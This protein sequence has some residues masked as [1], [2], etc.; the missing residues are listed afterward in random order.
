MSRMT[1]GI[2]FTSSDLNAFLGAEINRRFRKRRVLM[3]SYRSFSDV[4]AWPFHVVE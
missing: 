4:S 1:D 2:P 3:S